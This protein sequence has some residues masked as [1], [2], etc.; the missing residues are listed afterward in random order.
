MDLGRGSDNTSLPCKNRRRKKEKKRQRREGRRSKETTR[1][2]NAPSPPS[3]SNQEARAWNSWRFSPF[4]TC[5]TGSKKKEKKKI[6]RELKREKIRVGCAGKKEG[7]A[8]IYIGLVVESLFAF[9]PSAHGRC[10]QQL[11][12][13][14]V[15]FRLLF[16]FLLSFPI[17]PYPKIRK[18]NQMGWTHKFLFTAAHIFLIFSFF[19]LKLFALQK[20][21]R[22][23]NG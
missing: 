18:N 4:T 14:V 21:W 10:G 15:L 9:S 19:F 2:G 6:S 13:A 22:D 17:F 16:Y 5:C 7:S 1:I 3:N 12:C 11:D 23:I 8:W 20:E